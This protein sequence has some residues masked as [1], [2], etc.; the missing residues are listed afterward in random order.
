M[1]NQKNIIRVNVTNRK[2][3]RIH[4]QAMESIGAVSIFIFGNEYGYFLNGQ[5]FQGIIKD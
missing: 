1:E 5:A 4:L 3:V 2:A